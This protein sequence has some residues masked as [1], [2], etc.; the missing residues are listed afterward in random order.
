MKITTFFIRTKNIC[1]TEEVNVMGLFDG[2]FFGRGFGGSG[3]FFG[4]PRIIREDPIS[5]GTK[6]FVRD[7]TAEVAEKINPTLGKVVRTANQIEEAKENILHGSFTNPE[8]ILLKNLFK[9]N[10]KKVNPIPG[11]IVYCDLGAGHAEHSGVYIGGGRIVELSGSGRIVKVSPRQFTDNIL[12]I[13]KTIYVSAARDGG[14]AIGS[15][16]IAYRAETMIGKERNY[17]LIMD[18]CHQ[19]TAGCILD[20]FDNPNNFLWMLKDVVQNDMNHGDAV[21]W[22]VWDWQK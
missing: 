1:I 4:G 19:F 18:N 17:N 15:Q 3:G 8:K 14:H 2:G 12:T 10:M 16:M 6:K 13:D 22:L 5:R 7:K 20:D 11:S 21:Q 9:D